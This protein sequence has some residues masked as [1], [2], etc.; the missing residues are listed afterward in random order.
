MQQVVDIEKT[1]D[2]QF[3]ATVEAFRPQDQ[4]PVAI[5]SIEIELSAPPHKGKAS[6]YDS[7]F[8]PIGFDIKGITLD[9]DLFAATK[10]GFGTPLDITKAK[11]ELE[12]I[13]LQ[14][15]AA[16]TSSDLTLDAEGEKLRREAMRREDYA[17]NFLQCQT[18][19]KPTN[20]LERLASLRPVFFGD[21]K[22]LERA[23]SSFRG[24][25]SLS[26]GNV[27]EL[28]RSV[29]ID[30]W[31]LLM[32]YHEHEFIARRRQ[33]I[34]T[35]YTTIDGLKEFCGDL[36]T[37]QRNRTKK[38]H[39]EEPTK[40]PSTEVP[41]VQYQCNEC[42]RGYMD[43]KTLSSCIRF[44][45]NQTRC[46]EHKAELVANLR[47]EEEAYTRAK[48][49]QQR[50]VKAAKRV[51]RA[52]IKRRCHQE[53]LRATNDFWELLVSALHYTEEEACT[54]RP[55]LIEKWDNLCTLHAS[56]IAGAN[57]K[58][59]WLHHATN[60]NVDLL[61][62][63]CLRCGDRYSAALAASCCPCEQEPRGSV[64]RY[65]MLR[66]MAV[67]DALNAYRQVTPEMVFESTE[68]IT[69]GDG[70]S[71]DPMCL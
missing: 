48:A 11:L 20:T 24:G 23:I 36:L 33:E 19:T 30:E 71:R 51:E 54:M 69:R 65:R 31:I 70:S 44:H 53:Q 7:E 13:E 45:I 27:R 63:P 61:R 8:K 52:E 35:S 67:N 14:R 41:D 18:D 29:D 12:L 17:Q 57:K 50:L 28:M 34:V 21:N 56:A 58:L 46:R 5:S 15:R 64:A 1:T 2:Q 62:Y 55:Q 66:M 4:P 22:T 68:L 16:V 6:V 26:E 37:E 25:L 10:D 47:G 40:P 60:F 59:K 32:G 39:R 49:E 42:D 38:T 9:E 3:L 43:F